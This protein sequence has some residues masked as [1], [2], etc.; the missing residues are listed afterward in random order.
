MNVK[1]KIN[2]LATLIVKMSVLGK[3]LMKLKDKPLPE[4]IFEKRITDNGLASRKY[5]LKKPS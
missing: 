2:T 4:K 3:T 5:F 1:R